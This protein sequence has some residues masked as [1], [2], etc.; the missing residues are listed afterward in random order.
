MLPNLFIAGAAKS[1]T[2]FIYDRL[3][4]R[5]DVFMAELKEPHYFCYDEWKDRYYY[6]APMVRDE[7]EYLDLFKSAP[8]GC[9]Y[10]GEATAHYLPSV[11]A[12]EAIYK[13][14]PSSRVVI[15]LREPVERA[16]SHYLMDNSRLDNSRLG[17]ANYSFDQVLES[18]T[19]DC[20][21]LRKEYLE[22]GN[23]GEQLERFISVFPRKNLFVGLYEQMSSPD[24]TLYK[25]ICEFLDISYDSGGRR[26]GKSNAYSMP[27]SELLK[28]IY[29]N[30]RIRTTVG[31]LAPEWLRSGFKRLA[32]SGTKPV[33]SEKA[34]RYLREYYSPHVRK[35]NALLD[36][37]LNHWGY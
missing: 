28:K 17:G 7:G 5:H 20:L 21:L 33:M 1:G 2:T 27:S 22:L 29:K 11:S 24:D 16:F 34:R 9:K 25:D 26:V 14:N 32:F 37:M 8:S 36:G 23:Y 3:S 13:K 6:H 18:E 4:N 19:A 31:G 30:R 12:A 10:A 35:A 15:I